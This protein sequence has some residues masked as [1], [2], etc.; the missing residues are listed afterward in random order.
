MRRRSVCLRNR[1]TPA[2]VISS[3]FSLTTVLGSRPHLACHSARDV[4]VS[5]CISVVCPLSRR[6][7]PACM[8]TPYRPTIV[9]SRMVSSVGLGAATGEPARCMYVWV[10]RSRSSVRA[11][12]V[13]CGVRTPRVVGINLICF[14][15]PPAPGPSCRSS[16]DVFLCLVTRRAAYRACRRARDALARV[17][18]SP[19]R[20]RSAR[21]A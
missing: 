3:L 14:R 8:Q 18:V 1:A 19:L 17:A 16:I 6:C 9:L 12:S 20:L 13:A 21:H 10:S 4:L 11:A 5:V 15:S 2:S 7:L